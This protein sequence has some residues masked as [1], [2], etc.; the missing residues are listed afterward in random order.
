MSQPDTFQLVQ[1]SHLEMAQRWRHHH[2]AW[3]GGMPLDLYLRREEALND[4][5][6]CRKAM[7][8]WL[9]KN[10]CDEI[11][12]SCETYA[13]QIW[14]GEAEG[15]LNGL[16][17][18]TVASVLV[19]P[20]LRMQGYAGILMQELSSRLKFEG[21][22][23]AALYSDVG[24][25]LY[26]RAGYFLHP[27]RET[28]RPVAGEPWPEAA[29]EITLAEVADLIKEEP[30]HVHSRLAMTSV[31]AI[32]EVPNAERIAWFTVR[33]QFRAWARG[34]QPPI[35]IGARGPDGGYMLWATDAGETVLHAL[36]WRPRSPQDAAILAQAAAAQ[37]IDQSLQRVIWWDADRDT[38]L[39]PYRAPE[40]QPPNALARDRESSLPML[41]WLDEKRPFPLVWAG[42]E[43]FGW[44]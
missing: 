37:A 42:I 29:D 23:G 33:S 15:D 21:V 32:V 14:Y 13:A 27:S 12:A 30:R 5:E 8:M 2:H 17:L 34:Q 9:L 18:E 7:R 41:T 44:C 20:R 6:L 25:G 4:G 1:A 40:L 11:L 24:P 16:K 38:G 43:R 35:V 31:P 28:V 3:G 36:L 22:A 19:E 10:D 39:D 26:R